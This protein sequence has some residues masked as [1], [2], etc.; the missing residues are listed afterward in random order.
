MSA[1]QNRAARA[2]ATGGLIVCT[3]MV[4]IDMTIANVAL[5]HIQGSLSASQ[6]Q[7]TWMLTSYIVATAVMQPL[8]GWLAAKIGRKQLFILSAVGFVAV[9]ILCGLATNLP[10]MVVFRILQGLTGASLMPLSQSAL[11][12]LWPPELASQAMAMWSAVIMAAPVLGPTLGGWLTDTVSW[13]WCFFINLPLGVVGVTAAYFGL[14]RD[15]AG[16]ARPFDWLGFVAI[17]FFSVSLQLMVDRGPTKDWFDSAEIWTYAVIALCGLYVFILQTLTAEHPFFDRSIFLDANFTICLVFGVLISAVL[18]G[19]ISI[20]PLFM[21]NLLG[22]SAMQS[23]LA[24][25]PRGFGALLGSAVVPW[26]TRRLG[27]RPTMLLGAL[28]GVG[29]LWRMGHFD[30]AMTDMPIRVTGFMQ[31]FGQGLLFN[32][33]TVLSFATIPMA[34]RTEAAVLSGLLR[35]LGGSLGIAATTIVMIRRDAMAH[36]RLAENIR[37][38]DP[39]IDWALPQMFKGQG[40]GLEALNHEITRQASMIGYDAVF[41]LLFTLSVAMLPLIFVMR[42][43]RTSRAGLEVGGLKKSAR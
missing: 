22:Y 7:M 21:Q 30:L 19:S 25:I 14:P 39:L 43:A 3:L 32:P 17:V 8:S 41:G 11:L 16:Q 18:F 13:R 23:G 38:G 12:D 26:V 9:S 35:N 31:G 2:L 29:A 40:A 42:P 28:I 33:I 27:A 37:P 4:T 34:L 6:E 10:E 20:M 1:E 36:E 5:P 24:T 15:E